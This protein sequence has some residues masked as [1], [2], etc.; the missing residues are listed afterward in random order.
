MPLKPIIDIDVNDGKFKQ[1]LQLFEKYREATKAMPADWGKVGEAV[2]KSGVGFGEMTAA[3]L[4]QVEILHRVEKEQRQFE[5]TTTRTG[6]AMHGLAGHARE[7]ARHVESTTRNLLKWS[8]IGTAVGGLLGAGGLF[9]IDRLAS[10]ASNLRT[11]AAGVGVNPAT[12][13]AA[14][15]NFGQFFNAQSA[16][17]NIANLQQS[18]SG[19]VAFNTLGIPG[20]FGG[21][22]GSALGPS[23][24][25]IHRLYNS[26]PASQ[27]QNM[28]WWQYATQIL[29]SAEAVRT[30]G[31]MSAGEL[32]KHERD[33]QTDVSGGF[34]LGSGTLVDAQGVERQLTRVGN[35][36]EYTFLASLKRVMPELEDL[37][38]A[39][40]GTVTE[41]L[42]GDGFKWAVDKVAIGLHDFSAW[43]SGDDFKQDIRGFI[44]GVK[45]LASG[46]A[47][48]AK[49]FGANFGS[50]QPLGADQQKADFQSWVSGQGGPAAGDQNANWRR[51]WVNEH[52][53][54][55]TNWLHQHPVPKPFSPGSGIGYSAKALWEYWNG[56]GGK[57]AA[58]GNISAIPSPLDTGLSGTEMAINNF[59][60][61][62]R[63]GIIAG[64]IGGGF[65]SFATPEQGVQAAAH[66]LLTYQD[67]HHLNTIRGLLNRWAP[68]S[69]NGGPMGFS[70]LLNFATTYMNVGADQPLNLHD[71]STLS[72]LTEAFIQNEVGKSGPPQNV[73]DRVIAGFTHASPKWGV[74]EAKAI[75]AHSASTSHVKISIDNAT[76]GSAVVSSAQ[77]PA[78]Y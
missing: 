55:A 78:L 21:S 71:A 69:D 49:W 31:G 56:S 76:G 14:K 42:K 68:A 13:L 46:V 63:A 64:P 62:R 59:G 28:P 58:A 6:R 39:L 38:K 22:P 12:L 19:Q 34:G 48:V 47:N 74:A 33:Y 3:L 16:L 4:A 20:Q 65:Q 77:V 61:L 36:L 23:L 30:V 67:K 54:Q 40:G 24:N 66:L 27:R 44:D 5:Q 73:V 8:G 60:G 7:V 25:A 52:L 45:A 70:R 29:G 50:T 75:R 15:V 37:S 1:F 32:R 9:G 2:E 11:S 57:G 26:T 17:G 51:L 72:R 41:F 43:I 35:V 53:P 10:N 18:L